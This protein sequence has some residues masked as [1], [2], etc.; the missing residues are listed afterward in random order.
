MNDNR[1]L[2]PDWFRLVDMMNRGNM[3]IIREPDWAKDRH[4]MAFEIRHIWESDD[5]GEQSQEAQKI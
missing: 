5:D 2:L 4:S 3:I 1:Q